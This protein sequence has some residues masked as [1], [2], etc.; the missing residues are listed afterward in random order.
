MIELTRFENVPGGGDQVRILFRS[1]ASTRDTLS[2]SRA[3]ASEP[4]AGERVV[5]AIEQ[6]LL[7]ECTSEGQSGGPSADNDDV[8]LLRTDSAESSELGRS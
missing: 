6:Q 1:L 8:A 7:T 5:G 2:A 4:G 3:T